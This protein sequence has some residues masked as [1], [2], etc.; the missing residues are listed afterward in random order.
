MHDEQG[1]GDRRRWG[2]VN[3]PACDLHEQQAERRPRTRCT[4]RSSRWAA[5]ASERRRLRPPSH[6]VEH[7][8]R[9]DEVGHA[10]DR[11]SRRCRAR[12]GRCS[13]PVD[14]LHHALEDDH[15]RRRR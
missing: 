6:R 4:R 7:L 5:S 10:G 8:L 15:A 1:D 14:D 2:R 3:S 11:P 13:R 12:C 9:D